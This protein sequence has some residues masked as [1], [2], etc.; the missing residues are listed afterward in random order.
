MPLLTPRLAFIFQQVLQGQP[1]RSVPIHASQMLKNS[2]LNK[3]IQVFSS[4]GSSDSIILFFPLSASVKQEIT[5]ALESPRGLEALRFKAGLTHELR[6]E[7]RP[8][9]GNDVSPKVGFPG[10]FR[11]S[12]VN[13]D[14]LPAQPSENLQT[15]GFQTQ[16]RFWPLSP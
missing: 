5:G 14:L 11:S 13:G 1:S 9:E 8:S 3:Q 15:V 12:E 7:W 2:F 10:G 6:Q 4:H 16:A